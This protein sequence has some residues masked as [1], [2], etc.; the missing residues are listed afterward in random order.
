MTPEINSTLNPLHS[1]GLESPAP[2]SRRWRMTLAGLLGAGMLAFGAAAPAAMAQQQEGLV[3]VN[4]GDV[5]IL[6]NVG[7]GV[8]VQA[9]V[10]VCA[11]VQAGQVGV[12]AQQVARGGQDATLV[13]Q[14]EQ[15]DVDVP[16]T[17]T[18]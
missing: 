1:S 17:I 3:N 2:N 9:A 10:Q 6:E 11:I 14:V 15:G 12:L 7:V 18:R 4:V 5:T 8:G 13:C 16:V